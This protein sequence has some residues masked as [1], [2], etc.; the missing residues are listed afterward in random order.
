MRLHH[1]SFNSNGLAAVPDDLKAKIGF[2][3]KLGK[4]NIVQYTSTSERN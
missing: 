3:R 4:Y 2:S 1:T